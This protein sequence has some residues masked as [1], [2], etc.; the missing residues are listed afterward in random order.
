MPICE[1][2]YAKGIISENEEEKIV[3]RLTAL[4]LKA[5]GLEDN[6]KS[7]S[8]CLINMHPSHSM[9]IGGKHTDVGKIVVKIHVFAEAYTDSIKNTLYSDITRVFIDENKYTGEQKGNNVWC[10]II[11]VEK[12][13]FGVG[14]NPVTL[15][16]V[17]QIVSS[18]V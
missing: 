4:L 9:Y 5:E 2:S 18:P 3:E 17:K 1:V 11:P 7:R 16:M 8:V 14:G 10:V 12:N 6:P 13:N 15:E